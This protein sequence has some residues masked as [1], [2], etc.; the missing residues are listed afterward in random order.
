MSQR[1]SEYARRADEDYATPAWVG[2]AVATPLLLINVRSVWEPAA[3]AGKLANALRLEGF[4]VA[5]TKDD[6]L[7]RAEPPGGEDIDAII[8]N[9][10]Y[11]EDHRSDLACAFIRHALSMPVDVVAMLLRVDF[12][13]AKTRVDLFRDNR[14]FAGKIVL[15][16]RIVWFERPGAAPSEN[17][18]WFLWDNQQ[19]RRH[20]W[21]RY[22]AKP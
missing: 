5:A 6:F 4:R 2:H 17:H 18:A 15:L 8:T 9:P 20:P 7:K 10:P 14:R 11:G 1:N 19:R 12:D 13:S 21:T 22:A 16:D 3:G